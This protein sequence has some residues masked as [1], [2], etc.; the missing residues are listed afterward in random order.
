MRQPDIPG[1]RRLRQ[2]GKPLMDDR[3]HRL[4]N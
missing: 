4:G 3:N 1:H 2:H